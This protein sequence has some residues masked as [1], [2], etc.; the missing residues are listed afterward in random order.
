MSRGERLQTEREISESQIAARSIRILKGIEIAIW[1]YLIFLAGRL[2]YAWLFSIYEIYDDEGYLAVSLRSYF[3]HLPLY[4]STFT[5]YG[6]FYYLF[7]KALYGIAHIPVTTD[8]ARFVTLGHWLA[9]SL[10]CGFAAWRI[11]RAMFWGVVTFVLTFFHLSALIHEPNHPQGLILTLTSAL[12]LSASFYRQEALQPVLPVI[13]A[14]LA[15]LSLTKINIGSYLSFAFL[16]AILTRSRSKG[17]RILGILVM[18]L[19]VAI[20]PLITLPYITS[21]GGPLAVAVSLSLAGL[22]LVLG[23]G[24]SDHYGLT[25]LRDGIPALVT[26]LFT[27]LVLLGAILAEGTTTSSAFAGIITRPARMPV[28]FF[29]P[30]KL[31]N[32]TVG[33]AIAGITAAGAYIV[34]SFSRRNRKTLQLV[35]SAAKLIWG[36]LIVWF[37]YKEKAFQGLGIPQLA[38]SFGAPFTWLLLVPGLKS[39]REPFSRAFLATACV[40]EVMLIYPVAGTQHAFSTFLFLPAAVVALADALGDLGVLIEPLYCRIGVSVRRTP[41]AKEF[42][43]TFLHEPVRGRAP[44]RSALARNISGCVCIALL[45]VYVYPRI[46]SGNGVRHEYKNL[47]VPSYLPGADRL[48]MPFAEA[49]TY[50]VLVSNIEADCDSFVAEPGLGSLH[51]WTGLAPLTGFNVSGWMQFLTPGEQQQTMEKLKAQQRPCVI[52]NGGT[53][54]WWMRFK[55]EFLTRPLVTYIHDEFR[56]ALSVAGFELQLPRNTKSPSDTFLLF[57]ATHFDS[58][59]GYAALSD[60]TLNASSNT[61]SLW[62]KTKDAGALF[63]C[64]NIDN[65]MEKPSEWLPVLSVDTRGRLSGHYYPGHPATLES[66]VAVNNN[67]WHQVTLVGTGTGHRLYLDGSLVGFLSGNIQDSSMKFC[68]IGDGF[69]KGWPDGNGSWMRFRGLIAQANLTNRSLNESEIR[70]DYRSSLAPK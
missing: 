49:V 42:W 14:L 65:L 47:V 62:F 13:A 33:A 39:G 2:A 28:Q 52:Y 18:V 5:Q 3:S 56:P 22:C 68:E 32:S 53:A 38:I 9:A 20:P 26:F 64:Q 34:F 7:N 27:S 4:T 61:L 45:G 66:T 58:R 25:R 31:A 16:L 70:A 67:A 69:T 11:T 60:S 37:A 43:I 23:F 48:R 24:N 41:L 8:T 19:S 10:M 63:G 35:T 51:L 54:A 15:C 17:V 12:I 21:W 59:P 46:S 29:L 6:P 44:L 40:F 36:V 50:H 55:T 30:V 1:I 57:K